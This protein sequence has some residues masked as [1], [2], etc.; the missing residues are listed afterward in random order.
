MSS[1]PV[2]S[3]WVPHAQVSSRWGAAPEDARDLLTFTIGVAGDNRLP[4]LAGFFSKAATFNL[5]MEKN[6][7]VFGIPRVHGRADFVLKSAFGND[8]LPRRTR[9]EDAK[10]AHESGLVDDNGR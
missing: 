9:A 2:R 4:V 5:A 6:T 8:H 10:H 7:A 1:V 3:S